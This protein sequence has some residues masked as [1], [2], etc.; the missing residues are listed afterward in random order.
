MEG[1]GGSLGPKSGMDAAEV[2]RISSLN[3][4]RTENSC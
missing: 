2:R 1:Q 4:N 3:G